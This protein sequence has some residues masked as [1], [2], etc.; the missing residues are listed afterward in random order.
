MSRGTSAR[1]RSSRTRWRTPG[2][3]T[4]TC[5]PTA[6]AVGRTSALTSIACVGLI[7]ADPLTDGS[8]T[9]LLEVAAALYFGG[10]VVAGVMITNPAAAPEPVAPKL[11][12][13]DAAAATPTP[14][15][16]T[17]PEPGGPPDYARS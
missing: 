1:C 13:G 4:P 2:A 8:F 10:A 16:P 3:A 15:R 5:L 7:A 9:R 6:A 17:A 12:P 11:P 14:I